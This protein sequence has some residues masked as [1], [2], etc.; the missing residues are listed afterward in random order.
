MLFWHNAMGWNKFLRGIL[1]VFL[2]SSIENADRDID[3]IEK[4]SLESAGA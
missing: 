4:I 2:P 1:F 3:K